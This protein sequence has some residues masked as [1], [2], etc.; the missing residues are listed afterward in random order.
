M[1]SGGVCCLSTQAK[2]FYELAGK[3]TLLK[4]LDKFAHPYLANHV[5][6]IKTGHYAGE[7]FSH[8]SQGILEG[9]KKIL[10]LKDDHEVLFY[11]QC[12]TGKGKPSLN[13]PCFC[14]S[15]KIYKRC[16]LLNQEA[17][18]MNVPLNQII[19]DIKAIN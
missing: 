14:G 5:Y 11:L 3:I 18:R 19:K 10:Q 8:G 4:W 16:F 17:H 7:E 13:K 15:G 2:M 9:W 6:K 1:V 12:L